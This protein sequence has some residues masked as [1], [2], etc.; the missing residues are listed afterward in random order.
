MEDELPEIEL[1]TADLPANPWPQFLIFATEVAIETGTGVDPFAMA[2]LFQAT[3]SKCEERLVK[4]ALIG[5]AENLHSPIAWVT[6]R[7]IFKILPPQ[8]RTE[9]IANIIIKLGAVAAQVP[10]LWDLITHVRVDQEDRGSPQRRLSEVREPDEAAGD[11][12]P[13]LSER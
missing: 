10:E 3:M 5:S 8:M 9:R 12:H 13:P 1:V 6:R 7:R 2:Q 11:D 4:K